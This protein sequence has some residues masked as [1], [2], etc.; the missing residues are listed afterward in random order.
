[1]LVARVVG[2]AVSTVKDPR[3]TGLKLLIVQEVTP[4]NQLAGPPFIAADAVGAGIGEVVLVAT[5]SAA[6]QTEHT[7]CRAV[8]AAIVGVLDSLDMNGETVFVKS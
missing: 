2:S 6:R 1:M 7:D 3:L 5:G 4:S 8:D